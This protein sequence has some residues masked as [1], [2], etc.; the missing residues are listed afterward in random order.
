MQLRMHVWAPRPAD[1]PG[2]LVPLVPEV[3]RIKVSA[4]R[5]SVRVLFV[6]SRNVPLP[7]ITGRKIC[8]TAVRRSTPA[9]DRTEWARDTRAPDHMVMALR[10]PPVGACARNTKLRPRQSGSGP[11]VAFA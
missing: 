7:H 11:I 1:W 5:A 8:S 3:P 4:V 10:C 2:M 6:H 9:A